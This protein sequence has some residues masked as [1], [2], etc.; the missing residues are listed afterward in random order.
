MNDHFIIQWRYRNPSPLLFNYWREHGAY[1]GGGTLTTQFTEEQ[2]RTELP[3]LVEN[4]DI[5]FEIIE[6]MYDDVP[7][8][9][10]L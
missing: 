8:E 4:K 5:E 1:Y 6:V 2:V 3:K 9:R 7:P 10:F